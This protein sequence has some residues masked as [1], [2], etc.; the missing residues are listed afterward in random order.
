MSRMLMTLT[1]AGAALALGGCESIFEE[2]RA[3][4]LTGGEWKLVGIERPSQPIQRLSADQSDRHRI[5]FES[6]GRLIAMLDCNR[7]NGDWSAPQVTVGSGTISIGEIA[8]TRALCPS[9]SYGEEMAASLPLANQYIM[10]PDGR[11]MALL[12]RVATYR[13]ERR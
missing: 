13:F 5:S 11:S 1:V 10:D 4:R 7:G 8:A 2:D 3:P 9:P 12:T 6:G